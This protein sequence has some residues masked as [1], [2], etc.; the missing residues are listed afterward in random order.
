MKRS[1]LIV[2]DEQDMLDLLKR[3]LEPDLNCRVEPAS[4]GE[5]ALK[6]LAGESFDLVLADIKMPGMDGLELLEIIKRKNPEQTVVMMT[7]FGQ[8]ETAVAAMKSGAYDF[9]TKPFEHDALLLR[10]EKALERSTLL[11]ENQRLQ[12]V[13][14]PLTVFQNLVGK[15]AVMQRLYETIQMAAKTDLT[16]LITGESGTGKDLTARAIHALAREAK[17]PS[18]LSTVRPSPRTFWKASCS[19]TARGPSRMPLKIV[20]ASS[21]RLMAGPFSWTRSAM[22]APP[23]RPSCCG[24]CRRRKSS[25]WEIHAPSPWM[26]GSSPRPIRTWKRK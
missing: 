8:I 15:S 17:G 11:K 2:D 3:S 4:S 10:L 16:V 21:R 24:C 14:S 26:R 23:S 9:I 5:E 6:R 20:S 18:W 1:I 22:S 7:A 13:C 19:A 12:Q 25:P